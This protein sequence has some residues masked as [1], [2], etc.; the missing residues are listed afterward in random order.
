MEVKNFFS[1]ILQKAKNS[2]DPWRKLFSSLFLV[3]VLVIGLGIVFLSIQNCIAEFSYSKGL[4][5]LKRGDFNSAI[6]KIKRATDLNPKLDVYWRDLSQAY[7]LK[8][9]DLLQNSQRLLN[10]PG[11]RNEIWS[12]AANSVNAGKKATDLNPKNIANWNARGFVLQSMIGIVQGAGD[13]AIKSYEEAKKIEDNNPFIYT[14]LGRTYLAKA[15]LRGV[16]EEIRE[17]SLN[18]ALENLKKAIE[19]KSDYAPAHFQI[20][21]VYQR[22]GKID[23]AIRKMEETKNFASLDVGVAFQLG[24]LYWQKNDLDKAKIEFERA[25]ALSPNY[26][27]ARYF[28]GLIYDKEGEKKK[29]IEQFERIAKFNPDNEEVKKILSNLREG[30]SAL[31]GITS[32]QILIEEKTEEI[33]K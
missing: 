33:G 12:L 11:I 22:M 8:L 10:E 25:V 16:S 24:V 7:I 6:A 30:K 15:N 5:H 19:L 31:E 17:K 4:E 18:L 3:F 14:Q 9:N 2:R 1:N 26:S 29:A 13:W 28:L 20:A 23:E 27:N 32:P 21:L